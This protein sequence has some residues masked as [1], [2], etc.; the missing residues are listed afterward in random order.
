LGLP[1]VANLSNP[2]ISVHITHKAKNVAQFW[3]WP[4]NE[5]EKRNQGILDLRHVLVSGSTFVL[6]LWLT[7]IK[8]CP[9]V[10]PVPS[11]FSKGTR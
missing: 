8:A 3:C 7:N 10:T 11:Y 2:H 1:R 5:G 6:Q 4:K 9:F